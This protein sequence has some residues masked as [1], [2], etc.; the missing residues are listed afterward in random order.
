MALVTVTGSLRDFAGVAPGLTPQLIFKPSGASI[1]GT[2]S[3]LFSRQITVTPAS[4][5]T[6][7]QAFEPTDVVSPQAWYTISI[8]WSEPSG[9]IDYDFPGM[10]LFVPTGGPW[11]FSDIVERPTNPASIWFGPNAPDNPTQYT[12]WVET[13]AVPPIYYEWA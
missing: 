6:W 11:A 12:G 4:D 1:S 8:R 5:G 7:S 10:R 2:G 9:Y 13:D 3:V